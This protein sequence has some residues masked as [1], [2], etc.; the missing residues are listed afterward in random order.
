M[1][2]SIAPAEWNRPPDAHMCTVLEGLKRA[3]QSEYPIRALTMQNIPDAAHPDQLLIDI[4]NPRFMPLAEARSPELGRAALKCLIHVSGASRLYGIVSVAEDS[5]ECSYYLAG[6][7]TDKRQPT[8]VVSR[9]LQPHY[10]QRLPFH[11][12]ISTEASGMLS[13]MPVDNRAG[14]L[15]FMPTNCVADEFTL[16]YQGTGYVDIFAV[17]R[18]DGQPRNLVDPQLWAPQPFQHTAMQ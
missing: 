2:R 7:S 8:P 10:L 12:D 9:E 18:H 16:T 14:D 3:A 1:T 5:T 6:F 4:E 17:E 15:A 13:I 11:T